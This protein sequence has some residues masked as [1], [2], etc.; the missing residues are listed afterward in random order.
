[1]EV[2]LL[3]VFSFWLFRSYMCQGISKSVSLGYTF[4]LYVGLICYT[5]YVLAS[6]YL[7][8]LVNGTFGSEVCIGV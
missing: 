4:I 7:E 5:P 6:K 8:I 3:S 1:M 2:C